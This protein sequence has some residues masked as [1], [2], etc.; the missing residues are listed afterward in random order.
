MRLDGSPA[1]DVAVA[2]GAA[3][4]EGP[5]WDGSRGLLYW[6]DIERCLLH[7]YD[8][9][10]GRTEQFRTEGAVGGFTLQL[11]GSLLLFMEK[12][13]IR[14]WR[15]G[16]TSRTL[17]GGLTE[18]ERTRFNDAIAD[19]SG[20]VLAGTLADDRGIARLYR[21]DLDGTVRLLLD[22]LTQSN[23]MGFTADGGA[24]YLTDTL[25]H[26]IR[27]YRYV[28]ET[29]ELL[30]RRAFVTVP[31]R[32]GVP[33]GLTVDSEGNVWSA[34]WGGGSVMAYRPD[35]SEHRA[36]TLPVPKVT[37]VAFGGAELTDLYI[38][39]A[40]GSDGSAAPR[41]G[42]LFRTRTDVPGRPEHRSRIAL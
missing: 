9:A 16:E 2:C 29:G 33:D 7:R 10:S 23:G 8:P 19:P 38:T 34:R 32:D 5:L 31:E 42:D 39:T 24:L 20:R 18:L 13:A 35:G 36:I 37:S 30:D 15:D 14:M 3:L 40:G 25:A 12:G 6:V 41:P 4:G 11:D 1:V 27:L 28:S 21:V 22:D 26:E 17:V